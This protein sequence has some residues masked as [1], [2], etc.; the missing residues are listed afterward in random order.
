MFKNTTGL[1]IHFVVDSGN[2]YHIYTGIEET[3]D[4][5]RVADI[6][7]RYAALSGADLAI[8]VRLKACVYQAQ[9]IIKTQLSR[10]L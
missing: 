9:S 2:G 3:T 6:T 10:W 5:A 7:R 4:I 8:S 1:F